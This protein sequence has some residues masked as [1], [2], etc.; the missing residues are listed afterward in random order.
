MSTVRSEHITL[1]DAP[2]IAG[3]AFRHFRGVEDYPV[4]AAIFN[5]SHRADDI[6]WLTDAEDIANDYAHL[7]NCDPFSDVLFAEVN[8]QPVAFNRVAWF[9]EENGPRVYGSGGHVMPEWRRQGIGRAM[10]RYA[11]RRLREIAAQHDIMSER[12]FQMWV[13]DAKVG[14]KILAADEGYEPVRYGYEMV[15]PDLERLPDFPLPD[16]LEIRP[17][18]PDQYRAIWEADQEAFRDHW[19]YAPATETDYQGWL[20]WPLFEPGV[21]K[22]A[23]D[24]DQIAGQVRNFINVR[25]NTEFNRK[26]GYTEFISVRRPWRRRG[27]ARALIVESFNELKR[28]GMSEAALGVDAENPN[29]ALQ[30]YQDCGFQV[31]KTAYTYRKAMDLSKQ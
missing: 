14:L 13:A 20:G 4:I 22:I 18:T 23:W 11:E 5:A 9:Q 1:A 21:W 8:G 26:R 6:D 19:G 3:L 16:G 31:V 10:L 12:V 29:G 30:V 25:E 28:R 24:G 2:E 7:T 15:R 27:L 17:V